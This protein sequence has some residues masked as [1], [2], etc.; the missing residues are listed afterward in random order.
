MYALSKTSQEKIMSRTILARLF[1]AAAVTC[2]FAAPASA[3]IT[4]TFTAPNGFNGG[5]LDGFTFSS[6]WQQHNYDT[7]EAPYMEWYGQLHSITYDAGSF[8]F[9]SMSLG[10]RPWDNFWSTGTAN[11]TLTFRDIGGA[12]IET[13]V[14]HLTADNNFYDFTKSIANVHE[15]DTITTGYWPRLN[16][17]TR[18]SGEVPEPASLAL[19]GL[20][21]S[22]LLAARRKARK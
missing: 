14:F 15:I 4:T 20:G 6:N 13:D 7:R 3:G 17:I 12:A 5:T 19:L 22:G 1:A 16:S 8:T 21:L 18:A 10:G 11:V 9:E 2:A